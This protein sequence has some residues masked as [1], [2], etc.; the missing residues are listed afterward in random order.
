VGL[1]GLSAWLLDPG[2]GVEVP[3]GKS[4]L[5]DRPRVT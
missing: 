5:L 2:G 1:G 3:A 4:V